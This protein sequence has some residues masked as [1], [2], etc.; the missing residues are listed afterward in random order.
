MKKLNILLIMLLSIVSIFAESG[1]S[2]ISKD[3]IKAAF[4]IFTLVLSVGGLLL[5]LNRRNE[6]EE[7]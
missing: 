1:A 7:K 3:Y 5:I 4:W 6:I 2:D